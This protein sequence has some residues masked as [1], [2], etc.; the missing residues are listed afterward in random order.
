[1]KKS[2]QSSGNQGLLD[3]EVSS[4]FSSAKLVFAGGQNYLN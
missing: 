1:M 4:G 3:A 2:W